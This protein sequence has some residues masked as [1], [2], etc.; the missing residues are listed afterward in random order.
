SVAGAS[1]RHVFVLGA[2]EGQLPRRL[3]DGPVLP[4]Q[5]RQQLS[6]RDD[7]TQ[8]ARREPATIRSALASATETLHLTMPLRFQKSETTPSPLLQEL[9]LSPT[10][11]KHP[12]L[13]SVEEPRQASISRLPAG[14]DSVLSAAQRALQVEQRRHSNTPFDEFDGITGLPTRVGDRT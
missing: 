5:L 11:G 6:G 14:A 8:T 7:I 9:G 12:V 3:Q 13:A 4:W 10:E 2:I 1:Y